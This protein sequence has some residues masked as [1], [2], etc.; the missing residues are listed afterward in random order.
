MKIVQKITLL[1][2]LISL[3]LKAQNVA[4]IL[5]ATGNQTYCPQTS[6]P[7]V[8]NMSI[9]D[10]DNIGVDNMYIQISSGYVL[11]E[12][13]LTLTGSHPNIISSWNATQGKLTL[14]GNGT[15]P[16]YLDLISAIEDIVFFNSS[17][18]PSGERIFSI[19]VGQANYL[20][21]TGHYYQFIPDLGVS[22]STAKTFAEASTYYGLQ[23]YLAT[24]TSLDEV[25]IS[26]IQATGA[27][28][29]GG[30][31]EDTEGIWKW[32]S[33][34]EAG[35]V[36]WNGGPNGST[37]NFA[38]WNNNEPN[39][40][41]NENYAHVTA[42]GV[43]IPGSWNDL[44]V[45]GEL[46]GDYQPKGYIVEYG[47]MPN[48][49][50]LQISTTSKIV[51]PQIES[52]T[53]NSGCGDASL[54]LSASSNNGVINWYASSSGGL[55]IFTGNT[56][57]TP[58]LN[59]T[60]TYYI[61]AFPL[62]C[63]TGIRTPVTAI[64]N[65]IPIT[66][67]I[68]PDPICENTSAIIQ[69]NTNIGTINWYDSLTNTNPLFSGNSYTTPNLQTTTS[70]FFEA[71]NNG[72]VSDRK[73]VIITV[74]PIPI[75]VDETLIICE[76]E[77]LLLDAT[78]LG[79]DYAWS[80]G[81]TSQSIEISLEGLYQVTV[82]NSY[83]CSATKN[84]NIIENQA[85]IIIKIETNLTS[86]I[87]HT[88]NTGNFEYSIDGENY[89]TT[90]T[91]TIS[92]GGLYTAYVKDNFGCGI[93]KKEFIFISFP[94]FFTPNNDGNNDFWEVKGSLFYKNTNTSIFDRYGNLI[95]SLGNEESWNGNLNNKKLPATDY[96]FITEIPELNQV[97]KGHFSLIR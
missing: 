10:P 59:Q 69:A 13:S 85:P 64:I 52:T 3:T 67:F 74:N 81:E 45:D 50:V 57:T 32:A 95:I 92:E 72:C 60:T 88:M 25:Q 66:S 89:Y 65:Q 4:P 15:Q 78:I 20:E 43:G 14:S 75:L 96:W 58:V 51:I 47:G 63:T 73:E 62:G 80:T 84:F 79:Q 39:N 97:I 76:N 56:F 7:I 12:D 31:D 24:I 41:G 30:T 46:G 90:N 21:S 82:T 2:I 28:W 26:S 42:P 55:P 37:P 19:T 48:D 53:S 1:F 33:G 70:Y 44:D 23:G 49:P 86:V 22:W 54:T 40:L 17:S 29:I 6:I 34:P 77:T 18:T 27:G 38:Y 91:F 9:I 93:A 94:S 11:G 68:Q 83:G 71:I 5:N 36:F 16:T 61:D 8:T 87:I 35:T